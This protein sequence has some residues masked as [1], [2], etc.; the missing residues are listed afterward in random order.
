MA[1]LRDLRK[2][3][4]IVKNTRQITKAMKMVSASK[5]RRSQTSLLA[6]RPYAY[7]II[8]VMDS[9]KER[10]D[11]FDHPLLKKREILKVRLLIVSS[12]KR[13]GEFIYDDIANIRTSFKIILCPQ[14]KLLV[15]LSHF[16]SI[17]FASSSTLSASFFNCRLI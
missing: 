7:K 10:I 3:I 15:S 2:R 5:L 14:L 17:I 13:I 12:K 8:S 16:E 6:T 11:A 9:L 4:T 1:S